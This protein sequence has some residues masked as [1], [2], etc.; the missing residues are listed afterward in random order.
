MAANNPP[1][2]KVLKFK[3]SG[4]V[5]VFP[6]LPTQ[7]L[8]SQIGSNVGTGG[9]AAPAFEL[10][11]SGTIVLNRC[12]EFLDDSYVMM[13]SR[14]A[15]GGNATH[16]VYKKNQGGADLWGRVQ[17]G[18][19]NGIPNVHSNVTGLHVLHPAGVPTLA[20]LIFD[21]AA[22]L[23]MHSTINGTTGSSWGGAQ[24]Q[25][26]ET[27]GGG[28]ST[29]GQSIIYRNTIFWAH[30][31]FTGGAGSGFLT[32]YNP[33]T[34]SLERYTHS[35]LSSGT[36]A[37]GASGFALHVHAN[38]LFLCGK[39]GGGNHSF[40]LFRLDGLSLTE[41][42][43]SGLSGTLLTP[44]V[45]HPTMFTDPA[46]GDLIV[47]AVGQN[48][49]STRRTAVLRFT[50]PETGATAVPFDISGSVLGSMEGA[51]K[52]GSGGGSATLDRRWTAMVDNDTDAANPRIHLWTWAPGGATECWE[53][54]STSDG[55]ASWNE[56]EPVGGLAGISDDFTLPGIQV[57]GGVRLA[58][59]AARPELSDA[60]NPSEEVAGG[61]KWYFRVYG[62][63]VSTISLALYYDAEEEAPITQATLTGSVTVESGSPATV[64]SRSGNTI[65]NLT[66]DGGATL[67]SFVHDATAD[68]L[69]EGASYTLMLD[70]L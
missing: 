29:S 59:G 7:V 24:G 18:A 6:L 60:S 26:L 19:A 1:T 68:L 66:A 67:Y 61:T 54:K 56:L 45:E 3:G 51:D 5:Q 35:N 70:V 12:I 20:Y 22:E 65:I 69:D 57:G 23:R 55:G 43:D 30:G 14:G 52:Y 33:A 46:T 21:F 16:G 15:G 36:G 53:W 11:P 32:S 63:N 9:P 50:N 64:P 31:N 48:L 40:R 13:A 37:V 17:G 62:T 49:S 27:N 10:T 25:L 39:G 8:G 44:N 42:W 28:P 58:G 2:V 47:F 4:S 38:K 34:S 41:L